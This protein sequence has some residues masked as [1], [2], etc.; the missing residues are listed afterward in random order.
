MANTSKR[1][2]VY[3]EQGANGMSGNKLRTI[4]WKNL[5]VWMVKLSLDE[6]PDFLTA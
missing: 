5:H 2:Y 1:L 4:R 6:A 3:T